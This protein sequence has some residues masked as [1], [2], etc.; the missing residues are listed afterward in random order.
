MLTLL[1]LACAGPPTIEGKVVDVWGKPVEG[2]SIV[3]EGVVERYAT[4]AGGLFH[5][6]TGEPV[7]RVMAGKLGY[8]KEVDEVA[9]PAEKGGDYA[10]VTFE[11]YPEPEKPGFYA[12]GPES[13]VSVEPQRI[14]MVG[15]ELRHYA[16][17][18]DI[19]ATGLTAGPGRFV[20]TSRLRASELA[21]MNLHLSRLD[22]VAHTPVKGLLGPVDA[23]VNLWTAVE[24][25]AFDLESLPSRDDYLIRTR[26]ALAPGMYAFHAQDVLDETDERVFLM[27]PKEMQVAFPFEVR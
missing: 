20:F 6:E 8:I 3:I 17:M 21:R 5:I 23:T 10:P 11:L 14:V 27:M 16:G 25:I 26:E 18:R 12:V 24:E 2:A 9:P 19:P 7:K 1:L 13:Y 22:F 4:D 15:T